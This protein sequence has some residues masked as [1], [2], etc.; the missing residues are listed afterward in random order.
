M[1]GWIKLHRKALENP[2][3]FK[4]ADHVAVWIYLL[5]NATHKE[6]PAMFGG[7][8]ITLQP[9]QLITGRKSISEKIRVSESKIQRILSAFENEQQIEQQTG[10]KNRVVSILS[11]ADYQEIEQ[12]NE[13]QMNNNRTTNE[14]QVNTNKNVRNKELKNERSKDKEINPSPEKV[15]YA[16]FVFMTEDEYRKLTELL[17]EENR[18]RYFIRFAAWI[19]GQTKRVQE[20]RSAYLTIRN[21][22]ND[23]L[24]KQEGRNGRATSRT[25][26]TRGGGEFDFLSL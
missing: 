7:E 17:G 25:S 1:E 21:W 14:Q 20:S 19:S 5:L 9:G 12:Q 11:W 10:N 24:K 26:N 13:P 6:K 18:E 15:K 8:K 16:D 3:V 23:D 22:H 2:I 4:D